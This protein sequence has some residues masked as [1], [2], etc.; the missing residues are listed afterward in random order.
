[1][2]HPRDI[3]A[4]T[5]IQTSL[6]DEDEDHSEEVLEVEVVDQVTEDTT[7]ESQA[8]ARDQQ[9][10]ILMVLLA[11]CDAWR[12]VDMIIMDLTELRVMALHHV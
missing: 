2:N 12:M 1:M 8:G 5:T 9:V 6:V 10:M 11:E 7:E 4:M 3:K